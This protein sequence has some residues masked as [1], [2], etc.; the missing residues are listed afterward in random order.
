MMKK[1][2]ELEI[3]LDDTPELFPPSPPE[4]TPYET[5]THPTRPDKE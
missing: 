4:I 1:E 3:E 2:R 5:V